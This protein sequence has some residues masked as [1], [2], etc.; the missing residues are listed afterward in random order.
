MTPPPCGHDPPNP[1][2]CGV[3][4]L[5]VHSPAMREAWGGIGPAT[6]RPAV[7]PAPKSGGACT[8]LR[9]VVANHGGTCS[10]KIRL[11]LVHGTCTVGPSPAAHWCAGCPDYDPAD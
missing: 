8:H 10:Q 5:F 11:C 6:P 9:R 4:G 7:A 3:C 1:D 2:R